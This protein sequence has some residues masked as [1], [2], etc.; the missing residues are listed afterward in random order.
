MQQYSFNDALVLLS[1]LISPS[2]KGVKLSRII[3]NCAAINSNIIEKEQFDKSMSVLVDN[4]FVA[5][6]D[7]RNIIALKK[8]RKLYSIRIMA[9]TYSD[10]VL[11]L[12]ESMNSPNL[13]PAY[14]SFTQDEWNHALKVYR[15][16]ISISQ[17]PGKHTRKKEFN[18]M[19]YKTDAVIFDLDGTLIDSMGVWSEVDKKYFENIGLKMPNDFQK[20]IEGMNVDETARYIKE[21]YSVQQSIEQISCE[22]D[23]LAISF[24][25]DIKL[26]P[27]AKELIKTLHSIGIKLGVASSSSRILVDTALEIHGLTEYFSAIASSSDVS[28]GKPH[29]EIYL[30]CAELLAIPPSSCLVFEDLPAGIK[31]AK[32]AG[33]R[34]CAID[35]VYSINEEQEKRDLADFY[36]NT[37]LDILV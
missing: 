15:K 4:G 20:C 17:K 16:A 28:H 33:M 32:S 18:T 1:I 23:K 31:A 2:R 7:S 37:Y 35:D 27:G 10:A 22:I 30:K 8:A 25:K 9:S 29:P 5:V 11:K 26:K 36:I 13:L 6:S 3:A 24:Y 34:V 14:D 21:S 12:L 19:L